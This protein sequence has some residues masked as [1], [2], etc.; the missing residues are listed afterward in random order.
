MKIEFLKLD[1]DIQKKLCLSPQAV[2]STLNPDDETDEQV[3]KRQD[4]FIELPENIKD[5]LVSSETAEK[6]KTVCAH[7]NLE[8]LQMAPV[9]RVI[10][11]YY[12][13]E[14]KLEDF[15]SVIEKESKIK[16]EEAESIAKYIIDRIINKDVKP[17]VTVR[18]EKITIAR[19]MEKYP[20]IKR[21]HLTGA[22]LETGGK[23]FSPT[24][25]NW[26]GD[27]FSVVGAGNRDVMKRSS[28]LYHSKNVKGLNATERQKLSK[29]LKSLDE[30]F[31]LEVDIDK[32]EIVFDLMPA[33]NKNKF[34]IKEITNNK[35]QAN[36]TNYQNEEATKKEEEIIKLEDKGSAPVA[37]NRRF[38]DG[39]SN[40]T[41]KKEE[42]DKIIAKQVQEKIVE[43]KNIDFP[44]KVENA[45]EKKGRFDFLIGNKKR[46]EFDK[47]ESTQVSN[48]GIKF[49]QDVTPKESESLR[50]ASDDSLNGISKAEKSENK[51]GIIRHVRGN[52]WDLGSAHFLKEDNNMVK[53]ANK[54]MD[55][56]APAEISDDSVKFTSP[57]QLP[58][59]K[60]KITPGNGVKT[61]ND[62]WNNFFGKIKPLE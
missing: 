32:K 24:I 58:V 29:I 56:V 13:G 9:A 33:E 6:I 60:E 37:S 1:I 34:L 51:K 31:L 55:K 52:N 28:Y 53:E 44:K 59:E 18:K 21:Q 25:E 45:S 54:K 57:Q 46:E 4:K 41:D 27:Y 2:F 47:K 3:I 43:L 26:I 5:K 38:L 19:A 61:K 62:K 39:F 10:R 30:E 49:F 20:E 16:K 11:S 40:K 35:P 14:A 42:E 12:F 15:A 8:L 36:Q 22:F 50:I 17:Q 7:F 48:G 23:A